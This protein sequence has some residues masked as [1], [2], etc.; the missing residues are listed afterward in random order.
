MFTLLYNLL[1]CN[2]LLLFI[3]LWLSRFRLQQGKKRS[4]DFRVCL[5]FR[6]ELKQFFMLLLSE[7][8]S[9]L[10]VVPDALLNLT[11]LDDFVCHFIMVV[12]NVQPVC[13]IQICFPKLFLFFDSLILELFVRF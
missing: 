12:A 6:L 8:K 3:A 13:P 1:L 4:W 2:L 11:I 9:I 7:S 10:F 5:R